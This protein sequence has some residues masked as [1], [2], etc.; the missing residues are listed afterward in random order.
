[1]I[2]RQEAVL[3]ELNLYP[4]WQ[5]RNEI[6]TSPSVVPLSESEALVTKVEVKII[7]PLKTIAPPGVPAYPGIPEYKVEDWSTLKGV[8]EGCTACKLRAGCTQPVFGVGEEKAD[9]V[10]V[11]EGPGDEEDSLGQPL[12]GEAGKLFDNMLSAMKLNRSKNVFIS[13]VV[14]C[15]PPENRTPEADEIATCIP[16]LQRQIALIQPKIIVALGKTAATALLGYDDS[17]SSLRKKL[18]DYH[19]IPLVAT[20][21]PAYLLR[22]PLEKAGAWQDLCLALEAIGSNEKH[23]GIKGANPY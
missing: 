18:H 14:K 13:H 1:M 3:R 23:P 2:T 21:D 11:G 22:T 16:Y 15:R 12:V 7:P 4:L 10:F 5:R 8:V 9:W 17:L 20:F 19:G 6:A